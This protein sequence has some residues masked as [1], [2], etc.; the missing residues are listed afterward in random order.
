[1]NKQVKISVMLEVSTTH[2][3]IVEYLEHTKI[4]DHVNDEFLHVIVDQIAERFIN[5]SLENGFHEEFW[6]MHRDPTDYLIGVIDSYVDD[7]I[8]DH[9]ID[10][11]NN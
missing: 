4:W 11:I 8:A 3:E 5:N 2:S 1:M 10:G 9:W 6:R 7:Y